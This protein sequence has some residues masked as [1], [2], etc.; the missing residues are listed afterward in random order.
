MSAE[1]FAKHSPVDGS[2]LPPVTATPAESVAGT[3]ASARKA[4]VAW[5]DTDLARRV[6]LVSGL[7]RRILERADAIATLVRQETGKP[8]EE[9]ALAEVLP[10]ADLVDYWCDTIEE[11]LDPDPIEPDPL[12]YPGKRGEVVRDPR[13]VVALI[14][15][16]NYPVAI[17]LRT[18]IPALLAGNAVV[19]KPSEVTPGCG[20]MLA[21]LFEGLLP[22]GVL[23]VVQGGA[24]VGRALVESDV[25]LVVFTGSVETGRAIARS[26]AERFVPCS[27]ELGGKDAAIVLADCDV[28]RTANG[29][30]WGAF[31]NA[32]QNC[33]AIE[34]VY[35]EAAIAED[36]I[37]RV[38]ELTGAL[39]ATDVGRMTTKA[40]AAKVRAHLEEAVAAGAEVLTGGL[41]EGDDAHAF[42]PTVL[43]IEGA[44]A[45]SRAM[46]EETFG[47]LLPI[48]VV[49]DVEEAVRLTND[50]PYALT[51]S[52]WTK[53]VSRGRALARR[54]RSGVVT[55]NNHAFTAALPSAPWTG[56]GD[57]GT[58][59]TNGPHCL[60]SLTRPRL[61]LVDTNRAAREL[62]WYPYT[63][64]LR[65][66]AFAM[67]IVR[68]G[69]SLL[70][71]VASLGR[72]VPA[73]VK[74]MLGGG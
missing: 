23:A 1:P 16:W 26:C 17:P 54:L 49:A 47:P 8:I 30:V 37:A 25:D 74:R 3:V 57:T 15:P 34:R 63:P 32:G 72:L 22:E 61:V 67:A 64:A 10:N 20:A 62:W 29:L 18:L 71:R 50:S 36:L 69:G 27:L 21:S 40:Q 68:G 38:V 11:L 7:K 42:P 58:G 46:T 33:A 48:Q 44:S 39:G 65:T 52:V 59:V 19:F 53:R 35:V 66:V 4:A 45:R 2:A 56:V 6:E 12:S 51:T 28:E 73:L 5:A 31:T 60:S 70:A 9:A 14:T 13:G 41:P 55:V 43:R 24:D